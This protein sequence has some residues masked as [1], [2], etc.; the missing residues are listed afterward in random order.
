[1][2]QALKSSSGVPG[3]MVEGRM[4]PDRGRTPYQ[5]P[6]APRD[7]NIAQELLK[8]SSKSLKLLLFQE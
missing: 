4:E 2:G 1:M 6:P 3:F 8:S 5:Y 7:S